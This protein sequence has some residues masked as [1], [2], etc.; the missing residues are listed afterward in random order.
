MLSPL[1]VIWKAL[2]SDSLVLVGF[3]ADRRS[4]LLDE[5]GVRQLHPW[6]CAPATGAARATSAWLASGAG[7]RPTV[8]LAPRGWFLGRCPSLADYVR[9]PEGHPG[10]DRRVP[11]C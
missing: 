8:A 4:A 10:G 1:V 5:K 2:P 6:H 9:E 3:P 7:P 11:T